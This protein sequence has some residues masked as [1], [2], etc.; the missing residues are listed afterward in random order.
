MAEAIE[1][2][3]HDCSTCGANCS[4]RDPKSMIVPQNERSDVKNVIAIMSGKGGV[5][6]SYVTSLLASETAKRGARTAILDADVTG[7][8][9]PKA[10][11]LK[12][13]K[14]AKS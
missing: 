14:E 3:T 8:S 10:F 1:N 11:G 2:C 6:K 4:S 5:G 12:K 7:P 13:E 9:I